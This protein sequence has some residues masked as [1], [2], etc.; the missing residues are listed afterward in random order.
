M[1]V[2]VKQQVFRTGLQ[3]LWYDYKEDQW[4]VSIENRT[5]TST[6]PI[7]KEKVDVWW[8]LL[9]GHENDAPYTRDGGL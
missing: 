1:R 2:R 5:Y 3:K 4:Y 8:C 7:P 9:G 6:Q